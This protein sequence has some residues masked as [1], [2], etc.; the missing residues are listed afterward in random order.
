MNERLHRMVNGNRIDL[1]DEE[2]TAVRAEWAEAEER[3]KASSYVDLRRAEY[4]PVADQLDAL[5]KGGEAAA[6]MK[7]KIDGVKE[8]HPKPDAVST[9]G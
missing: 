8:K 5:W 4:P 2:E 9:E 1:T 7:A 6:A 3:Q